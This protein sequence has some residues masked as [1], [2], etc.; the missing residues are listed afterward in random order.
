[1]NT[2]E[3]FALSHWLEEYPDDVDYLTILE[4][5][6]NGDESI[7]YIDILEYEPPESIIR[8]IESTKQLFSI[9]I[10]IAC[11]ENKR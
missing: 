8:H 9:Y 2:S 7:F 11:Q 1:M 10:R 3:K 5:I 4:M 6:E